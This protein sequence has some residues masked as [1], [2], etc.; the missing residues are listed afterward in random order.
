MV[1]GDGYSFSVPT[2]GLV[3]PK[4]LYQYGSKEVAE[5]LT[6][7][8]A[9]LLR[10]IAPEEVQNEAWMKKETKVR[11]T[12]QFQL[13]NLHTQ[14]NMRDILMYVVKQTSETSS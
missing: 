14:L 1:S 4:N 11:N 10:N 3:Q 6:L 13:Y 9:E 5:E 12:M 2:E 7:I 8:D